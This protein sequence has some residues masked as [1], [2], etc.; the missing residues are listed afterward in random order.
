M[1]RYVFKK[2]KR[3]VRKFGPVNGLN[4]LRG[5]R[6][7]KPG[8]PAGKREGK[9]SE[10]GKGL[11][12]KNK[13][14]ACYGINETQFRNYFA[15]ATKAPDTGEALLQLLEYRLDN[16]V[17]RLGF[18]PTLPGARQ[19]VVHGHIEVEHHRSFVQSN[20]EGAEQK[21]RVFERV[22][23]PSYRLKVGQRIRLCKKTAKKLPPMIEQSIKSVERVDYVNFDEDKLEG[24][25]NREATGIDIKVPVELAK[26]IEFTSKN[27]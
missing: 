7:G 26:I 3:I 22:D 4:P 9:Q 6:L 13:L 18:A 8:K 2:T 19:L 1:A 16:L 17:Y 14:R 27:S 21:E 11:F 25:L 23:R 10:Y 24:Y 20:E 12:N 15:K 5:V